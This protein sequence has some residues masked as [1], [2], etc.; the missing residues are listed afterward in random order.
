MAKKK[1]E[2]Q[3]INFLALAA[4]EEYTGLSSMPATDIFK[5]RKHL[6][7]PIVKLTHDGEA[8]IEPEKKLS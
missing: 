3:S 1:I 4:H 7:Q 2:N 8:V 6:P 5:S